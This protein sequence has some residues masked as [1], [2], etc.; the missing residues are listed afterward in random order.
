M[1]VSTQFQQPFRTLALSVLPWLLAPAAQAQLSGSAGLL[2]NYLY[3][4]ISLSD[5]QAA[6]RLALNY[7]G[8]AGWYVGGQA[9]NG[10]LA[11]EDHRSLQWTGYAGYAQRL[12]SGL[13]WETGMTAYAFP[14]TSNWNFREVYI[15]LAG[16]ALSGRLHYAPDYLG[17]GERTLYGELS[18][19][20]ILAP[21]WQAFWHGGYLYSRDNALSNRA[22]ARVGLAT[23]VQGWQAQVSL[24][25]TRLRRT[26]K[27]ENY[28][29]STGVDGA[30]RRQFVVTLGRSF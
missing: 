28:V 18:G 23:G 27:N 21:R 14:Q 26:T 3:R 29:G 1:R 11:I 8:A 25:L 4:G 9:V 22:E 17:F 20:W 2:S 10:Q 16:D 12:A 7:D 5:N 15:G 24:D 19:G 30:W 6:A 13:S